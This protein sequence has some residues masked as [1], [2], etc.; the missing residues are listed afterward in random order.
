M[1]PG[2]KHSDINISPYLCSSK[3]NY[4]YNENTQINVNNKKGHNKN[5]S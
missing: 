2:I 3:V 5:N 4:N 1:Q